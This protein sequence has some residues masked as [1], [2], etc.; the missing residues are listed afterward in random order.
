MCLNAVSRKRYKAR[1]FHRIQQ[2]SQRNP[3]CCFRLAPAIFYSYQSHWSID[4]NPIEQ[5]L[6]FLQIY[7]DASFDNS[8]LFSSSCGGSNAKSGSM[9]C[10][11]Y[12]RFNTIDW[13]IL[14][15]E[16][17]FCLAEVLKHIS[18]NETSAMKHSTCVKMQWIARFMTL[19]AEN[20]SGS[21]GEW[22]L[23]PNIIK[24]HSTMKMA[25]LNGKPIQWIH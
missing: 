5:Q 20:V 1:S 17:G 4:H 11:C 10:I 14:A 9:V 13:Y 2:Y 16:T 12:C 24:E 25:L 21:R 6:Y 7:S 23:A 8:C 18:Q 3:G 19:R 22:N 15:E